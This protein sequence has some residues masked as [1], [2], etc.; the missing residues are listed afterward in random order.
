MAKVQL[1]P[2]DKCQTIMNIDINR[3][4]LHH[5]PLTYLEFLFQ[6]GSDGHV[7]AFLKSRAG[8]CH[9]VCINWSL[10]HSWKC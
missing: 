4:L 10:R 2:M 8:R 5:L 9:T 7:I 3:Y 1:I 6:V